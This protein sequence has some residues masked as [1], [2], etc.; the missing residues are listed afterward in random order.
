MAHCLFVESKPLSVRCI[1]NPCHSEGRGKQP[2]VEADQKARDKDTLSV[3][4]SEVRMRLDDTQTC[5]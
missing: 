1:L 2:I 4:V 3:E 5:P